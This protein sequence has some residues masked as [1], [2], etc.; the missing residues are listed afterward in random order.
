MKLAYKAFD[1]A[2]KLV[3][4]VI[5]ADDEL[6]A[7]GRL[8]RQDLFVSNV[9]SA[10][11]SASQDEG[12]GFK[13]PLGKNARLKNLYLFTRQLYVLYSSGI[14]LV[15]GLAALERQGRDERWRRVVADVKKQ[16]E[17]GVSLSTA[18]GRHPRYFDAVYRNIVAAGE[19]SGTLPTVLE[20]LAKLT[21]KR[22]H[23][24]SSIRGALIYPA[25]LVSVSIAVVTV[26]MVFV[27]PRFAEL[28]E[29]LDVPL[30]GT[31]RVL[32]AV[33]GALR[34]Y[35]W[36]IPPVII[37]TAVL[38]RLYFTS[39]A[40]KR[41]VDRTVLRIPKLGQLVR[42]LAAAEMSRL[43]GVL[44]SSDLAAQESIGLTEES[45]SNSCYAELLRRCRQEVTNG[46]PMSSAFRNTHLVSP[47]VYETISSG[48][49]SGQLPRSLLDLA[50]FLDD[51][52]EVALCSLM[53]I[54]EPA[55]LIMMGLIVG[56]LAVSVFLPLFDVAAL[57]GGGA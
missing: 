12:G 57:T 37:G 23:I 25:L 46:R 15:K 34:S 32:I 5:E 53:S 2:G 11:D 33:S 4:G 50:D 31:T 17:Q 27:I 18:M 43:M 20:R 21:R 8:R 42:S 41:F 7:T 40:G 14:P 44:L 48:E 19:A 3:T 35:W 10:E 36:V 38:G 9:A 29:M 30:P 56:L 22:L 28:F 52:N 24:R 51:E 55:I 47:T 45:M 13:L 6:E 26:L 54:I 1:K 49:Q 39:K 16:V